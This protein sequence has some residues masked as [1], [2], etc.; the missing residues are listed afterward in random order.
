[1]NQ[2]LQNYDDL[3]NY[4]SGLLHDRCKV[5]MIS[6]RKAANT[7]KW[8]G[9]KGSKADLKKVLAHDQSATFHSE[10]FTACWSCSI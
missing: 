7:G 4:I 1:M 2:I 5:M 3:T 9:S 10:N 8:S 6:A